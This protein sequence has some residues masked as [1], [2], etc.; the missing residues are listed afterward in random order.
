MH[1][2]RKI[3]FV[4]SFCIFSL[5]AAQKVNADD[6]YQSSNTDTAS[7]GSPSVTQS[8]NTPVKSPTP[9]PSPTITP[10]TTLVPLPVFTLVFP[11]PTNTSTATI[12][13]I[14]AA[15]TSTPQM[16]LPNGN[17]NL[18]PRYLLLEVLLGCLWVIL[19]VFAIFYIRQFR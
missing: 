13:P 14:I 15:I 18:S 3:L 7:T 2:L 6:L 10:T 1:F 16:V 19:I 4:L 11:A 9:S 8:T 17:S 12:T 5:I